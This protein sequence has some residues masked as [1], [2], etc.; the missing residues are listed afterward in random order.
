M[1][2]EIGVGVGVGVPVGVFVSVPTTVGVTV[3][4]MQSPSTQ[5]EPTRHWLL[6]VQLVTLVPMNTSRKPL[7]TP[8][9]RFEASDANDTD[10]PSSVIPGGR[11]GTLPLLGRPAGVTLAM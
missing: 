7:W 11:S 5:N 2:H 10:C 4:A 6:S 9:T 1:K 3:G 8:G